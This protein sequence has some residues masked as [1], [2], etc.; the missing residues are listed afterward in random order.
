MPRLN[1]NS[2]LPSASLP[3]LG[4]V[5]ISWNEERNM[6][7][8]IEHLIPWVDEIVIVDDGSSDR[9]AELALSEDDKVKF[10]QSPRE[11]G[12]YYSHQRNKGIKAASSEWLLHMDIDERVSPGLTIEIRKAIQDEG[13]DAYRFHRLN[14]FLN[15]PMR[16]GGWQ[17]WNLVHLARREVLSF[18][19]MYHE[20]CR[21]DTIPERIGQLKEKMW[22]LN[23]DNYI[24]RIEKSFKYCQEQAQR[25]VNRGIKMR[26]YHLLLLPLIEYLRTI[27]KKGG[28]RDGTVGLISAL[29]SSCAMFRACAIVWDQQNKISRL[30]LE[31]RISENWRSHLIKERS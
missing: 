22:H 18:A 29:H 9:T 16:G 5:A 31:G 2:G 10:I 14:F 19:G 26:W 11:T 12:E 24:E 6:P 20:E 13:K 17:D 21:V 27:V 28:Y 25:L 1:D 3:S 7:F 8:F 30:E 4:V 23:E 15:R